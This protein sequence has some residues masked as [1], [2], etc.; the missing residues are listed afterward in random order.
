M[1]KLIIIRGPSAAGKS[2]VSK[3]LLAKSNRPTLLVSEDGVR[4]MFN[5]HDGAGHDAARELATQAVHLGLRNGYDVIYE[6]ILNIK[7]RKIQFDELL[8]A[9][10]EENYFFFLDVGWE[11][12]VKR[13]HTRPEKAEFDPEVM[14]KWW[15]YAS[16]TNH[17][18]ET[19]IP[20][21][22]SKKETIK[23]IGKVAGLELLETQPE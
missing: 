9:H 18:S 11:E 19:I 12:T 17:L 7:T 3:E 23:I 21:T 4:K 14:R 8:E 16:P 10:P 13:H 2:S 6:G 15:D 5:D 1:E 20:E 22:A